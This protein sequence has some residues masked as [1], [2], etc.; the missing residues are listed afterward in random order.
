[1]HKNGSF[2]CLFRRAIFSERNTLH[3]FPKS[4][5]L[6]SVMKT[7]SCLANGLILLVLKVMFNYLFIY[8]LI[9]QM[10]EI[11]LGQKSNLPSPSIAFLAFAGSLIGLAVPQIIE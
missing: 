11:A 4:A 5:N 8:F 7:L 3:S 10:L 2:E 6:N 1:M 9:G